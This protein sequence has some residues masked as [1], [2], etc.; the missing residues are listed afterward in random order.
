[1]IVCLIL[2]ALVLGFW[3]YLRYS[4]YQVHSEG[5][6]VR[7]L[8]TDTHYREYRSKTGLFSGDCWEAEVSFMC[9]GK[10]Y[11]RRVDREDGQFDLGQTVSCIFMPN[12]KKN[13]VLM[14]SENALNN[15]REYIA[16]LF[17]AMG[18]VSVAGVFWAVDMEYLTSDQVLMAMFPLLTAIFLAAGLS[19]LITGL[20]MDNHTEYKPMVSELYDII[21]RKDEDG[22][23][24]YYPVYRHWDGIYE[25]RL[26]SR[27]GDTKIKHKIGDEVTLW[28]DPTTGGIYEKKE[29][30]I[31]LV[32]GIIM[33]VSAVMMGA[34]TW[35]V[36]SSFYLF[37]F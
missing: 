12:K 37:G 26:T 9:K 34:M 31:Q 2:A 6:P 27:I 13:G 10:M 4:T 8:V 22:T 11:H 19:L 28:Q 30:A 5:V 21:E 33:L 1:M 36:S 17:I 35:S 20:R 7:A 3:C 32:L 15:S 25:Q 24:L 16:L 14:L 18:L 29:P 23:V